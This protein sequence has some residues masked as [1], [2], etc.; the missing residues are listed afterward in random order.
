MLVSAISYFRAIATQ[1]DAGF[2]MMQNNENS[3]GMLRSAKANGMNFNA[4]HQQDVRNDLDGAKNK[5]N[6]MVSSAWK[7][8]CEAKMKKENKLNYMA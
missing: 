5:F 8:Q 4:L 3:L 2:A 7:K 1:H 6:Y